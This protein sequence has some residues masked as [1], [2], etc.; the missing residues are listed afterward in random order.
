[1]LKQK[2]EKFWGITFCCC[3]GLE[4][5][6]GKSDDKFLVDS[7]DSD[8][9]YLFETIKNDVVQASGFCAQS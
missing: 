8:D 2:Y 3:S 9:E 1:M 4:E 7:A 6:A 5:V